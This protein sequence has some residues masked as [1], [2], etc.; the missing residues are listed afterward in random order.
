VKQIE[1]REAEMGIGVVRIGL[2]RLVK[3]AKRASRLVESGADDAKRAQYGRIAGIALKGTKQNVSRFLV[4]AAVEG[5]L[6]ANEK[7]IV[8]HGP[9]FRE[10]AAW[11]REKPSLRS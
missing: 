2:D 9:C 1:Q 3:I 10:S 11:S 8:L 6:G 7:T 5:G 4:T